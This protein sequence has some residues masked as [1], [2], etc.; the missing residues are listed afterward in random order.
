[1]SS[2]DRGVRVEVPYPPKPKARPRVTKNGTFMP[3]E[4]VE[5][6]ANVAE[7][8]ALTTG[9]MSL[10][11]PL[12]LVV[13]FHKEKMV[14]VMSEGAPKRFGRADIDNLMGGLMD[15]IELS[16]LITNDRQVSRIG[17]TFMTEGEQTWLK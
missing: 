10:A 2:S 1:M 7:V 5:W 12:S 15:A 16:G 13:E 17:A 8:V 11:G 6:K 3:K 14:F 9:K 4:Y